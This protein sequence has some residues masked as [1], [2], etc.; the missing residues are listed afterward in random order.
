MEYQSI[1]RTFTLRPNI[2]LQSESVT[3]NGRKMTRD[4]DYFIDYDIGIITFFNED[5]IRESTVI[6][7]TYEFAPFGGVLEETLVGARATYDVGKTKNRGDR[8]RRQMV[9]GL[10]LIAPRFRGEADRAA[11]YSV[12]AAKLARHRRRLATQGI[13]DERVQ[14]EKPICRQRPRSLSKTRIYSAAP[15]STRWKESSKKTCRRF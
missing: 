10:D 7:I 4:L 8:Q 3:V 6:E 9:G 15:S 13:A 2:V 11:G 1:V 14:V 12:D 5:L